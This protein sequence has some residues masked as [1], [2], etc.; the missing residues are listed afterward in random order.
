M[1]AGSLF[2]PVDFPGLAAGQTVVTTFPVLNQGSSRSDARFE[3]TT[4]KPR[5]SKTSMLHGTCSCTRAGLGVPND[6]RSLAFAARSRPSPLFVE[7]REDEKARHAKCGRHEIHELDALRQHQWRSQ[8]FTDNISI[9]QALC[10]PYLRIADRRDRN[11][12]LCAV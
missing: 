3:R 9:R 2:T 8:T 6:A 10:N 12:K 7:G 5:T 1:H 11:I 4:A